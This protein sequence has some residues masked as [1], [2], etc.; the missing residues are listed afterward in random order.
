MFSEEVGVIESV[1]AVNEIY[2]PV[3]GIVTEVN[4][5]LADKPSLINESCYDEGKHK[6]LP[7]FY[8]LNQNSGYKFV[9]YFLIILNLFLIFTTNI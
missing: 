9:I 5:K 4:E 3:S 8:T 2:S 1:K 6:Y 7:I